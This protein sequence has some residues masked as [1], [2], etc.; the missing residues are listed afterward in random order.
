MLK[1]NFKKGIKEWTKRMVDTTIVD[2]NK[3]EWINYLA[4]YSLS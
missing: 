2:K 4:L 3:L 1:D